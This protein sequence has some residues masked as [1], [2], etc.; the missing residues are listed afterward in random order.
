ML[1]IVLLVVATVG[2]GVLIANAV[3]SSRT[4]RRRAPA[5]RTSPPEAI[6]APPGPPATSRTEAEDFALLADLKE[7]WRRESPE[8]HV[9]YPPSRSP[10]YT[11]PSSI[12][13]GH[14]H[15]GGGYHDND[16]NG[17]DDDDDGDGD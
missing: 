13:T 16:D 10:S 12:R 3:L 6:P 4:R 9:P 11:G 1:L 8:P 2:A 15:K 7:R 17:D 5:T 14:A